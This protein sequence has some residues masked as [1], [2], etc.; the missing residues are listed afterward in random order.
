M[1]PFFFSNKSLPLIRDSLLLEFSLGHKALNQWVSCCLMKFILKMQ[2]NHIGAIM[3]L[4]SVHKWVEGL[5]G[6]EDFVGW[7]LKEAFL[8]TGQ[9]LTVKT[10]EPW[11]EKRTA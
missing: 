7:Q 9:E 3:C 6:Q 2:Q 11:F 5:I 10:F 8:L 4:P 1:S